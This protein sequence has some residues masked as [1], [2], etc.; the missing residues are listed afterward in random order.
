MHKQRVLIVDDE[1]I[2]LQVLG[3]LLS[4]YYSVSVARSGRKALDLARSNDVSPDLILLDIR[5]PEMDGYETCR[6]LQNHV[7]TKDIP[8]IFI[9]NLENP[10]D[11]VKAFQA[12]AVDYITKPFHGDEVLARVN[13]HLKLQN[14]MTQLN[15]QMVQLNDQNHELREL[16]HKLLNE[17]NRRIS[18]E[19]SLEIADKRLN[20]VSEKEARKWGLSAF[21]GK[22]E[23]TLSLINEIR[24]VQKAS[25]TNVLILGESGTGKELVARAIHFGS[26]RAQNPF[27]SINCSA[28]PH[29]LAD[30]IFFGSIKGSYTGSVENRK[31]CFEEADGGTLFLDEIGE[32]PYAIQTKLLR[33]LEE[34]KFTPLGS[35]GEQSVNVRVVAATNIDIDEHISEKKFREDL[36]Y[37]L[38]TYKV[39]VPTL[40]ERKEDIALLADHFLGSFSREMGYNPVSLSVSALEILNS[41]SFPG[42]IREL[43]NLMEYALIRSSGQEITAAHLHLLVASSKP[44][45]VS[46]AETVTDSNVSDENRVLNYVEEN[47]RINNR[48]CQSLLNT[49]QRRT[50]Y[51]LKNMITEGTLLKHGERRWSYYTLSE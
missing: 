33:V 49:D 23:K 3:K 30:S 39:T 28:V 4:E 37:R 20:E 10:T 50:S 14:Q 6:E 18:T 31:G 51:L 45:L 27:I 11:K 21:I 47:G 17:T 41:Y 29:D 25:R 34:R 16:N 7:K 19:K 12:G 35:Y 42:N 15:S 13:T 26:D 9:S 44:T 2:N 46:P 43:R 22:S 40:F 24:S 5:M 1:R 38:A 32:M 48:E 36:Y 8:V